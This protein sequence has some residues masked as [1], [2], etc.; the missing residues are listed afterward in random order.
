[1]YKKLLILSISV[2]LA[3]CAQHRTAVAP[4]GPSTPATTQAFSAESFLKLDEIQPAPVLSKKPATEPTSKPSLDAL[5]LYARAREAQLGNQKF[6]AINYLE[7]AIKLDPDSFELRFA[8]G[9]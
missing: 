3:G 4:G 1:M 2:M 7:Q 9:E 8:L 5:A 6:T